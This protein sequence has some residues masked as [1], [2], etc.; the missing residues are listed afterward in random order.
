MSRFE[1][2]N[3]IAKL[4]AQLLQP[5]WNARQQRDLMNSLRHFEALLFRLENAK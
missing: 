5:N 1:I 2:E 4:R 3:E